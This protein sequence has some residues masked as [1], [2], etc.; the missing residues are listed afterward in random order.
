MI[1]GQGE[2][3]PS[4]EKGRWHLERLLLSPFIYKKMHLVKKYGIRII[5]NMDTITILYMVNSL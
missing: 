3:I 1:Y 5:K 2:E 4:G